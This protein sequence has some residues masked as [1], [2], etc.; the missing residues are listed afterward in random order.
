MRKGTGICDKI[1]GLE[2][3]KNPQKTKTKVNGIISHRV[4]SHYRKEPMLIFI[5]VAELIL[6]D[7]RSH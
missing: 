1:I 4:K 2:P 6:G 7:P 3:K 5:G